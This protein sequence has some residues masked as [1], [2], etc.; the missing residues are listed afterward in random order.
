MFVVALEYTQIGAA[1]VA[2][3][4]VPYACALFPLNQGPGTDGDHFGILLPFAVS[5][6]C[7][8]SHLALHKINSGFHY[9]RGPLLG[10][11]PYSHSS[12][13]TFLDHCTKSGS[14]RA[15]V[16]PWA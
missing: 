16:P 8:N 5:E 4:C 14:A 2:Q 15:G 1:A 9:L 6:Y 10:H 3:V 11:T 13:A 7:P 12:E